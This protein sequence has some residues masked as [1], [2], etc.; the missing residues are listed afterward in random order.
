MLMACLG[1]GFTAHLISLLIVHKIALP[2]IILQ[3]E[4]IIWN[5]LLHILHEQNEIGFEEII[6][7]LEFECTSGAK[8]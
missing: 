3:H 8:P 4:K 7:V 1:L 5:N 6:L 2:L